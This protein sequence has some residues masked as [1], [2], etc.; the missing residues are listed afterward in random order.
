MQKI[1]PEL[2]RLITECICPN[3]GE[4]H[5]TLLAWV[6][7]G[8]TRVYCHGCKKLVGKTEYIKYI[9]NEESIRSVAFKPA[10]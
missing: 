5:E 10:P 4:T 9:V 3:C 6:G 7:S 1:G 8:I 2:K